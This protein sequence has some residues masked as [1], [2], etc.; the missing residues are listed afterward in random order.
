M[1][2]K[3]FMCLLAIAMLAS[4]SGNKFTVDGTIEGAT[5]SLTMLLELSSNGEWQLVDSVRPGSTGAFS[6]SHEAPQWP[7]IYRLRLGDK[8][9][10]FPIDSLDHITI[11]GRAD[12]FGT[13]YEGNRHLH[14]YYNFTELMVETASGSLHHSCR[15]ELTRQ[16]I[17]LP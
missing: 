14:R 2:M 5:D 8:S 13:S 1:S 15:S 4:C 11:K 16:G 3:H 7:S 12:A 6:V 10:C 9:I 17:S